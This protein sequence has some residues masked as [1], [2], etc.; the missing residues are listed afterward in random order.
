MTVQTANTSFGKLVKEFWHALLLIVPIT[1]RWTWVLITNI[2]QPQAK[3][4][5]MVWNMISK[6]MD[7]IAQNEGLKKFEAR[8]DEKLKKYLQGSD[9][10]LDFGCGTGTIALKFADTVKAIHGIDT[11]GKMIEAAQRKAVECKI[12]NVDFAQSTIFDERLQSESF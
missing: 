9:I 7:T 12:E 2:N 10:V 11:A 1:L 8:R 3:K 5:E 4:S 6:N